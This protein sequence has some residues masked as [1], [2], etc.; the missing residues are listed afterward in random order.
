MEGLRGFFLGVFCHPKYAL[1]IRNALAAR[2][3]RVS[4]ITLTERLFRNEG[5]EETAIYSSRGRLHNKL[6]GE[7]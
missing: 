5:T 7:I 1:V 6:A 2:F 4:A 3:E